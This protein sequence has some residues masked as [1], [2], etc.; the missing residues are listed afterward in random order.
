MARLTR[1]AN[2][3][4][5]GKQLARML[6]SYA[7]T[8]TVVLALPRG[9]VPVGFAVAK[10]LCLPLDVLIV[11]K[12][13]VPGYEELAMGAIASGGFRILQPA[14]IQ[15]LKVPPHVVDATAERELCEI[16]RR[17]KRYRAGRPV[18]DMTGRAVILIDDGLATGSTMRV[19]VHA[20]RE[21]QPSR[22]VVAVPVAAPEAC[23]KLGRDVDDIVCLLTPA[24]FYAVGAWYDEFEQTSD[25]EVITL[26]GKA[27]R[28]E[29]LQEKIV[30]PP[31]V[32]TEFRSHLPPGGKPP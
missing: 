11:R 20:V 7:D 19:A 9:G 31:L 29:V 25:D 24:V 16:E 32:S 4:Q 21:H 28:R 10:A 15:L 27:W 3:R 18:H 26:L 2:R 22:V 30:P 1:F 17:E 14:T 13:G 8:E 12:L 23:E 6:V 5:A